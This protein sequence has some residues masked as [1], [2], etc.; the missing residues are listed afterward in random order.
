[1]YSDGARRKF[2]KTNMVHLFI[3]IRLTASSPKS[4]PLKKSIRIKRERNM[5]FYCII[6]IHIINIYIYIYI[7]IYICICINIMYG[8]LHRVQF[9]I[10]KKNPKNA[11]RYPAVKI[12]LENY[13]NST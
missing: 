10:L 13:G 1:M 4:E 11:S 3:E 8:L 7:Y 6:V 5:L 9:I 12:N 2:V